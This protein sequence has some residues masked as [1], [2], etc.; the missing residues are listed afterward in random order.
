M[1]AATPAAPKPRG[2]IG[3]FP[4]LPIRAFVGR[5]GDDRWLARFGAG[6]S[7]LLTLQARTALW[8]GL[9]LLGVGAGDR[10]LVPAYHCGV[11]VDAILHAGAA[12]D[13]VR[14]M[15]DGALDASDLRARATPATRAVLAIHYFGFPAPLAEIEAFCRERG[16][17]L[18]EDRAHLLGLQG[19]DTMRSDLTIYSLQKFL[20]VPDGG[21]LVLPDGSVTTP[22]LPPA[23]GLPV[24]RQ[25][26]LL[27]AARWRARRPGAYAAAERFLL[28]PLRALLRRLA[29]SSERETL[30]ER[31]PGSGTFHAG[32]TAFGL[33]RFS[34]RI[35]SSLDYE[36][37]VEARRRNYAILHAVLGVAPG[38]DA[39]RPRL[40]PGVCP[41]FY[42][43]RVPDRERFVADLR[44]R[45]V[46]PFL[47]GAHLH[48][49]LPRDQHPEAVALSEHV[50]CLPVHQDLRPSDAE[51]VARAAL[52]ALAAGRE[53]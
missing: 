35:A 10:V 53:G 31:N 52:E 18:L 15:R 44:A 38:A 9:R 37:I 46:E 51:A 48:A 12:V 13:F 34:R 8:H 36:R 47:F 21:I 43:I 42:P 33:S 27:A 20:P 14:V 11:E 24:L 49:S 40:D 16:L 32:A 22:A 7:A 6:S 5:G 30:E 1:T 23:S 28:R 25:C 2:T 26:L 19:T 45:G 3:A 17:L 39:L 29:G 41:L 4:G 50:V